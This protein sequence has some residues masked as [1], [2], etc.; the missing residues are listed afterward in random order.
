[1]DQN[2]LTVKDISNI[3]YEEYPEMKNVHIGTFDVKAGDAL[4]IPR[5]FWHRMTGGKDRNLAVSLWF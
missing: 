1:M 5:G 3:N 2:H 4:Y